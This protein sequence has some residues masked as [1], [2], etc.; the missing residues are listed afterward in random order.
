MQT[1]IPVAT[2][3]P[4]PGKRVLICL[5][6]G[7]VGEAYLLTSGKWGRYDELACVEDIFHQQVTH[8]MPLPL[9]VKCGGDTIESKGLPETA[10]EAGQAD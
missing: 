1:W 3:L 7:F 5:E 10:K 4:R 6:K 8:W 2:Q 9:P